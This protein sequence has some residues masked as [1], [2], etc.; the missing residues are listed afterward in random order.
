MEGCTVAA[1]LPDLPVSGTNPLSR[2]E[3]LSG[4]QKPPGMGCQLPREA[5]KQ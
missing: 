2:L 5:F 1:G 3:R 4:C